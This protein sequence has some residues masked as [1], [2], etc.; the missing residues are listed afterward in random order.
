MAPG[1]DIF[2]R[3]VPFEAHEASSLYSEEKAR[4]L[5]DVGDMIEDKDAE[6]AVFLSSMKLEEI[7]KAGDNIAMPEEVI[8][9][10]ANLSAK[11]NAVEK[12]TDAMKRIAAVSADVQF[13]LDEINEM[14]E[15][16]V[17][18]YHAI[19]KKV[20]SGQWPLCTPS[21]SG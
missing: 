19:K 4:L 9:C 14:L 18:L 11:G 10:A 17:Q 21:G 7:P 16:G 3:L 5:R 12:L 20:F 15:V 6:L 8:E 2:A 1:P 13:S